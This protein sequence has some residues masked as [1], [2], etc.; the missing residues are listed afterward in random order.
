MTG[1]PYLAPV[2]TAKAAISP[3]PSDVL[4][5]EVQTGSSG[6]ANYDFIELYNAM[7][8]D[9]DLN[10]CKLVKREAND[11]VDKTITEWNWS[12]IMPAGSFYLWAHSD[13]TALTAPT[14]SDV[15]TSYESLGDHNSIALKCGT[16]YIDV[17]TWGTVTNPINEGEGT[18]LANLAN[19]STWERKAFPNSSN[20]DMASGGDDET[21]G[22]EFDSDDNSLNFVLQTTAVPQYSG[23]TTET[24]PGG[25]SLIINEVA[26]EWI[27][28]LNRGDN[29]MPV[30]GFIVK[31]GAESYTIPSLPSIPSHSFLTIKWGTTGTDDTVF[32]TGVGG[33][34]PNEL[35]I[36]TGTSGYTAIGI[37][38]TAD[39]IL[40]NDMGSVMD[41]VQIGVSGQTNESVAVAA[42]QWTPGQSVTAPS[43][44][45]HSVGREY[46]GMDGNIAADWVT[47][48]TPSQGL[49]NVSGGD[50]TPP[51]I[52]S[53]THDL[54]TDSSGRTIRIVFSEDMKV[55]TANNTSNYSISGLTIVSA[56][57]QS[58]NKDVLVVFNNPINAST[59]TISISNIQDVAGNPLP[60]AA[61]E[62]ITGASLTIETATANLP[63]AIVGVA[64]DFWPWASGGTGTFTWSLD[65]GTSLPSGLTLATTGQISGTPDGGAGDTNFTLKV[66]DSATSP[67]SAT[68]ALTLTVTA[69]GS[70]SVD[71]VLA[72]PFLTFPN[73]GQ[74]F[75]GGCFETI[76][77]NSSNASDA[78]SG[79]KTNPIKLEF[80]NGSAWLM[81]SDNLPNDGDFDWFVPDNIETAAG[82]IRITVSDVANNTA[83]DQ[84]TA[85]FAIQE[86]GG[87]SDTEAPS[88]I[89]AYPRMD[90]ETCIEF[91]EPVNLWGTDGVP[92]NSDDAVFTI[93]DSSS[94][95]L[96]V[97]DKYI[98]YDDSR[99]VFLWT[100]VQTAGT[101]YT[102]TINGVKDFASSPNSMTANTTV[103]FTGFSSTG[104]MIDWTEPF[105]QPT[106][107]T[108]ATMTVYGLNTHFL[109]GS[110]TVDF[111]PMSG[112]T[113]NSVTVSSPT[114]LVVNF[115]IDSSAPTGIKQINVHTGS[116]TATLFD[117]LEIGA[118]GGYFS[119]GNDIWAHGAFASNA[120]T[121]EIDFD[122]ALRLTGIDDSSGG[123]DDAVFTVTPVGGGTDIFSSAVLANGD[124]T[125]VITTDSQV[126]GTHY[127]VTITNLVS[128]THDGSSDVKIVYSG[129]VMCFPGFGS[130]AT[131]GFF[132]PHVIYTEP[133]EGGNG[134]P[135]DEWDGGPKKIMIEF[136]EAMDASTIT[137]TNIQINDGT[138][139]AYGAWDTSGISATPYQIVFT[140]SAPLKS[141]TTYYVDLG[142]GVTNAGGT[143]LEG[144]KEFG[145][146]HRFDFTTMMSAM[147]MM[148]MMGDDMFTDMGYTGGF[149]DFQ[150]NYTSTGMGTGSMTD[151]FDTFMDSNFTAMT[152][153]IKPPFI[154][155]TN[156]FPG[157]FDVPKNAK[158]QVIFSE[159]MDASSINNN[160]I[161]LFE[162]D[163]TTFAQTEIPLTFDAPPVDSLTRKIAS[164]QPVHPT[165]ASNYLSAG[166]HDL[167]VYGGVKSSVGITAGPPDM[168]TMEIYRA[169]FNVGTALDNTAPTIFGVYPSSSSPGVETGVPV[170][171]AAIEISFSKP[172]DPRFVNAT[173]LTLASGTSSVT[174]KISFDAMSNTAFFAPDSVLAPNRAYTFSVGTGVKDIAGNALATQYDAYFT[175]GDAD[176]GEP[177]VLFADAD[178]FSLAIEFSEPMNHAGKND[179]ANFGTSVLNYKNYTIKQ[180]DTSSIAATW[181]DE[182]AIDLSSALFTYESYEKE[183]LIEGLSLTQGYSFYVL[184]AGVVDLSGNSIDTSNDE[185][186]GPVV[187]SFKDDMAFFGGGMDFGPGG[188]DMM[189]G[190]MAMGGGGMGGTSS[191]DSGYA[192]TFMDFAPTDVFP[193]NSV[194][195]QTSDYMVNIPISKALSDGDII[196]LKFPSVPPS[197]FDV[198]GVGNDTNSP[199]NNDINGPGADTVTF[200]ASGV[201]ATGI[202][203]LTLSISDTNSDGTAGTNGAVTTSDASD[204]F[205]HLHIDL[206]GIINSQKAMGFG[207]T[208]Y[209][210][211][212]STVSG[213]TGEPIEQLNSFP[214]FLMAGGDNTLSFQL[215]DGTSDLTTNFDN[216]TVML[217]SPMMGHMEGTTTSGA[218][219]FTGLIDGDYHM[220]L[221][222]VVTISSV[223]YRTPFPQ[224]IWVSGGGTTSKD[225][226]LT[227]MSGGTYKAVSGTITESLTSNADIMVWAA[228]PTGYFEKK[229]TID[230]DSSP[231]NLDSTG[232]GTGDTNQ[233]SFSLPAG[234]WDIG[235]H[236]WMPMHFFG[237]P[238]IPDFVPPEP[239]R[240]TVAGSAITDANLALTTAGATLTVLVVDAANG[241]APISGAHVFA[242]PPMG[243]MGGFGTGGE[244]GGDGSV[245]L[246]VV[247]GTYMVGAHV[248]GLPP[249]PEKMVTVAS[250][251]GS[252]TLKVKKPGLKITGAVRKKDATTG[253]ESPVKGAFVQ[254]YQIDSSG[255]PMPHW[256]DTK[257]NDN[258]GEYTLYVDAS[259][260]WKVWA[261]IPDYGDTD[262]LIVPVVS[263]DVPFQD[264]RLSTTIGQVTGTVTKGGVVVANVGVWAEPTAW[265][266]KG[267][268]GTATGPDGTYTLNLKPGTYTIQAFESTLGK[269]A[270]YSV[271]VDSAGSI[272]DTE[273][274]SGHGVVDFT[275]ASGQTATVTVNFVA[276]DG[277]TPVTV[278]EASA[279]AYD[280]SANIKNSKWE[281]ETSSGAADVDELV[282]QV[283]K[284]T[285]GNTYDVNLSIPGY[286]NF[287]QTDVTVDGAQDGDETAA[288]TITF[289]LPAQITVGGE[290]Y[291]DETGDGDGVYDVGEG[292]TGAWVS[293]T[294]S[295][296]GYTMDCFTTDT[297]DNSYQSY[298]LTVPTPASGTKDYFLM[299]DRVDY[300]SLAPQ[301][302]TVNSSGVIT[303]PSSL[304]FALKPET[305]N[306]Y[307][308]TGTVYRDSVAT[309]N[310]AFVSAATSDGKWVGAPVD[311]D[312]TYELRVEDG[313]TWTVQASSPGDETLPSNKKQVVVSGENPSTQ[314][315]VLTDI[316]G[317]VSKPQVSK[318]VDDTGYFEDPHVSLD[319]TFD[320]TTIE[321]QNI[322]KVITTE[323]TDVGSS[324]LGDP[325]TNLFRKIDVYG[326]DESST[327]IDTITG[328][329]KVQVVFD[330]SAEI[331][332]ATTNPTG[333]IMEADIPTMVMAYKQDAQSAMKIIDNAINDTTNYTLTAMVD[334]FS[335]YGPMIPKGEG[336]PDAPTSLT[337]TA[338]GT[339]QI[340]LTWDAVGGATTGYDIYRSTT[341]GDTSPVRL[342]SEP[343][344]AVGTTTYSDTGLASATTY[345]YWVTAYVSASVESAVSTSANATT[346]SI[347]GGGGGGISTIP[348]P[349]TATGE[350]T[351]TYGGGG[352]TTIT[353][354]ENIKVSVKLPAYAVSKSTKIA[355]APVEIT[356]TGFETAPVVVVSAMAAVP[357][358]KSVVG[359]N[360]YNM[361]ATSSGV[362][363]SSFSKEATITLY[364]TD[365]QISGLKESG[366]TIS[367]W[368][369]DKQEWV[370]LKT[371]VYQTS[372]KLIAKTSHFTYFAIMGGTGEDVVSSGITQAQIREQ[373]NNIVKQLIVLITKLITVYQAQLLEMQTAD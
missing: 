252:V 100:G 248:P 315:I 127:E 260:T 200:S 266:S 183:V 264:F 169:G 270:P 90:D 76:T 257:V 327:P 185:A 187:D 148:G 167:I 291:D 40:K 108:S 236:P 279:N 242:H 269:L 250:D 93:V 154:E 121:V 244:T 267:S 344:V 21:F 125:V 45:A 278:V 232:N 345:Y 322:K 181:A 24:P 350:V 256:V 29:S 253:V 52:S 170:Q 230:F 4:I 22:N 103:N 114:Q 295:T 180:A 268:N 208:G 73:G 184:V 192:G 47:Y 8:E 364:Y 340:D 134:V 214:F 151:G 275:I 140:P 239:I 222:P 331:Y 11:S 325:I 49:F 141:S 136:S 332:D 241:D 194:V 311:E 27:E 105:F 287:S 67:V 314:N 79:L 201:A 365:A 144:N 371:T 34:N 171:I 163:A 271:T 31:K 282:I 77:W 299:V 272:T 85:A 352:K 62:T 207:T 251:T 361:T 69:S 98:G 293:I 216:I 19:D 237:P 246:K 196:T 261:F 338:N 113:I 205:D 46:D 330:Y 197:G 63:Y 219:S 80:Y 372:N 92:G 13:Y 215:T 296:T 106:G 210:V 75:F 156:P 265:A 166:K 298:S 302:I 223:D 313:F 43:N 143:A 160:N 138:A 289:T 249:I 336:A 64:Y 12:Q 218:V 277:V 146:G 231:N 20:T 173:N 39:V 112:I 50:V 304:D 84:S 305:G 23:S 286:G 25:A 14:S 193:K 179:T 324:S 57:L 221:E 120:T 329:E 283:P 204:D 130:T 174:G 89:N 10:G 2:Q 370:A 280:S 30:S 123:G 228:G 87:A 373:I 306:T 245:A 32:A 220:F 16:M 91:S 116:E 297:S 70:D 312:G 65:G 367:Y 316:S 126:E 147:N 83:T 320:S 131:G 137:S 81:I 94:N 190:G 294:D 135:T 262:E 366:L 44:G 354:S 195:S 307:L 172:M 149:S 36:Y 213:V 326:G 321:G 6:G 88:V 335:A 177:S 117:G 78:A 139:T 18:A 199:A 74:T 122:S 164:F 202:I 285:S 159:S 191:I 274:S 319:I 68:K 124:M 102:I 255:N 342:G 95:S 53:I 292:L 238:P 157:A 227:A 152:T 82:L 128:K 165:N 150:D 363:V 59:D 155:G 212:I 310:D 133:M 346:G 71:P 254:G 217:D 198:S 72:D 186:Y 355:I 161:K 28:I 209:S 226:V 317:Y 288:D 348:M 341:S 369:T 339:S 33:D 7:D 61:D 17:L 353:T 118:T 51:T 229:Y 48:E 55:S 273:T 351:A 343:T 188:G 300:I 362:A 281:E 56:T 284:N 211:E 142:V 101:T 182:T 145:L 119:G 107:V 240:V 5:S 168:P 334:S 38:T 359:G 96:P 189:M 333:T 276:S 158:M 58:N 178:P 42:T 337:A 235:I 206:T 323:A 37:T 263:A 243:M 360:V 111:T 60:Y 110:T 41:Y 368:D 3:Y 357:A 301:T 309:D 86:P 153:M 349:T 356:G 54:L 97:N 129:M 258:N 26:G 233:F 175:T 247:N 9:I 109:A 15:Q 225:I 66:T 234:T 259:T 104:P 132:A 318:P 35:V 328:A 176:S 290:I 303:V 99:K 308:I 224:P 115:D 1:V 358:S 162:V 203:T 347:S